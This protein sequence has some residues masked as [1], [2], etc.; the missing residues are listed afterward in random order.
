[1]SWV[2]F[3]FLFWG[4]GGD[5]HTTTYNT[6]L[7]FTLDKEKQQILVFLLEKNVQYIINFFQINSTLT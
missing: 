7:T 2:F 6:Q 3:G 1:M 5:Q 4:G